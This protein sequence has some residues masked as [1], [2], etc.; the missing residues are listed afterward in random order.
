[1]TSDVEEDRIYRWFGARG[2][3]IKADDRRAGPCG[4]RTHES[5]TRAGAV[6]DCKLVGAER[7]LFV[8]LTGARH[9]S[10]SFL[11]RLDL[12]GRRGQSP[13]FTAR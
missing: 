6:H 10:M 13:A 12:D 7:V 9:F 3:R 8:A 2:C 11:L 4:L 5:I 1:M